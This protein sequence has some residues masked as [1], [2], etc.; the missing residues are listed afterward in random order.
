MKNFLH[1]YSILTQNNL[2]ISNTLV[3]TTRTCLKKQTMNSTIQNLSSQPFVYSRY[4]FV[5]ESPM[6]AIPILIILVIAAIL[7][8]FGNILILIAIF[9]TKNLQRL[10]CIF[11][12]NLATSDIYVTLLADP[13]SIVGK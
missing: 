7:G 12:A 9:T 5:N 8:S 10:E 13:L 4:Q 1:I 6:V 11:M 3:Y 2:V